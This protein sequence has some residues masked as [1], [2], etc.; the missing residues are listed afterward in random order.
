MNVKLKVTARTPYSSEFAIFDADNRDENNQAV[1]IG[2]LDVHYADDQIVGTLLI[3]Q[4]YATGFNRLHG[5][6]SDVTMDTLIDEILTEVS[7]PLGVPGE[8]G[9][10]VYYPTLANHFFVS[11]Y[12]EEETEQTEGEYASEQPEYEYAEGE[13]PAKEEQPQQDD[14]ARRLRER[15]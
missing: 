3:W 1:N 15:T 9:I 2:K 10:E 11:T 14:F 6:G 8:Y 13:E 7:E 4:E 5:P 12:A